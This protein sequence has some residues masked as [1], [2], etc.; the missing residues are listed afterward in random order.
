[1]KRSAVEGEKQGAFTG[2]KN[3]LLGKAPEGAR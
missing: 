1:V 2:E 3:G